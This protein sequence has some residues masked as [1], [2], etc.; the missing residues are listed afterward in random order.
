MWVW[1]KLTIMKLAS[2]KNMISIKGIISMRALLCGTG[3]ESCIFDEIYNEAPVSV[4]VMGHVTFE[5]VPGLNRQRLSP[6]TAA[7]SSTGLPVLF[8]TVTSVTLPLAGSTCITITPLPVIRCWRASYGYAGIGRTT[9]SAFAW[10]I[11]IAE[12]LIGT[13]FC[14]WV[15]GGRGGGVCSSTN[16]GL[17][18]GGGGGSGS[19]ISSGGGVD[20]GGANVASITCGG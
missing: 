12:A 20:S 10:D 15:G 17:I 11:D 18:S 13:N 3:D 1:L 19:G 5:A 4:K 16:S 2:K 7:S 14:C 6:L 8:W 9:A